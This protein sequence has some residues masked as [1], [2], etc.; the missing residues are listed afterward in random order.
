M[1]T[2]TTA[3][4]READRRCI[5]ELGIPGAVLMHNAGSAVFGEI[6]RRFPKPAAMTVVCGK[7]NNGGDGWVVARLAML[8]GWKVTVVSAASAESLSG[9][10]ALFARVA[11]KLGI[12]PV[13]VTAPEEAAE[14][15]A[16]ATD[17]SRVVVDALL[18]TGTEGEVRGLPRALIDAWPAEVPTVAVDVPSGLNA[19]TGTPGGAAIRAVVTV[20]FGFAKVGLVRPAARPWVGDL[21]V[22]DIGIPPVCVDDAAW[23]A[24]RNRLLHP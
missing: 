22:A 19:D 9:D 23:A 13:V 8:A 6:T 15:L 20:T 12:V 18:G 5:E 10:A 1:V 14:V 2:V 21:V 7:G 24:L 4:M 11:L 16:A 17:G 3:Q